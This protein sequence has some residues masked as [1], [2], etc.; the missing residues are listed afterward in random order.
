MLERSSGIEK[1]DKNTDYKIN[2][3][4]NRSQFYLAILTNESHISCSIE[5]INIKD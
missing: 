3:S 4:R 2:V 5:I 1:P